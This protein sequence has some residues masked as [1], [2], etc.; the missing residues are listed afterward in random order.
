MPVIKMPTP[1]KRPTSDF[2]WIR[3]KVP[4][5]IRHLVGKTEV[6]ASLQ[7]KDQRQA[8]IR[9]G[10]V[11]AA[12]EADWTRLRADA[13][14]APAAEEAV[15]PP[16]LKLTHQDLH[17]IRGELHSRIRNAHMQEPPTGFGLVRIVAADEESLHLDAIELLEKG[18]Y[19]VSP[20]NVERLKPLLEKARGD[21]VKDLQHARLG[22]YDQI[23]DLTKIP[24][25]TTPAL[26]L[27][28][29]FEE[30]AAKGGLKGGKFGPTAKRWRPKI[31]AFC[32]FIGHRDLK[33]MTTADGY[34]WVD[35]LVEKGFA[36]KSIRDVWIAA[37]SATAGF[38]VERRK[39][40]LNAFRGIRVRE[41]DGAVAQREKLNSEPPRK[42]FNP[43][44]AELVLRG[45]LST[46]SH[47]ISAEMRAA[48]R[49]LPWLCAYSGARVNE[50]TSLY[51]E[52]I[53]KGPKNIWTLAIKPSLEKT[54]QWRVVPIHRASS[55]TSINDAS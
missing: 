11:N 49:W 27:I 37:L 44:E 21:A 10:A 52:D 16:P 8:F 22:E 6:W 42:G 36:R 38:M 15:A 3:K 40:D 17:A 13:A 4:E 50:L 26:D 2:Y 25:R 43:E 33:R 39:L 34:K 55:T 48:R 29:A 1:I 51:P 32:N 20:E 18:G 31:S 19:D 53:K 30:F 23:A 7:T 12:I 45:T 54:N 41:D 5:K 14:R 46:P 47:L 9:I 28:R 35:H 24:S